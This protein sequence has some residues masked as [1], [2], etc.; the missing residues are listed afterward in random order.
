MGLSHQSLLLIIRAASTPGI[1]P[2]SVSIITNI[3]DPQPLSIMAKGGK[4]IHNKTLQIDIVFLLKLIY[5][6]FNMAVTC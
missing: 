5:C 6:F 1:Q 2:I 4:M 3:I